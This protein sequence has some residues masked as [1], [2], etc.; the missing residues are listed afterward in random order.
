MISV[1]VWADYS[2][3]ATTD[4]ASLKAI[5]CY[6]FKQK[7]S[8]KMLL[9]KRVP[10]TNKTS[11]YPFICTLVFGCFVDTNFPTVLSQF[12]GTCHG[13]GFWVDMTWLY[14]RLYALSVRRPWKSL[15]GAQFPIPRNYFSFISIYVALCVQHPREDSAMKSIVSLWSGSCS[16]LPYMVLVIKNSPYSYLLSQVS[17][18]DCVTAPSSC[19]CSS[20]MRTNMAG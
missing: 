9:T 14:P 11:T 5:V 15:H 2:A 1:A 18:C 3:V 6:T 12:L 20:C 8:I 17:Q 7:Y 10:D 16:A 13:F 19:S 4:G